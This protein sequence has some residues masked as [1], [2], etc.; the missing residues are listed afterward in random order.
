MI[1]TKTRFHSV[2][3][4]FT[5]IELLVVIS[6]IVLLIALLLPALSEAK[7]TVMVTKCMSNLKQIGIGINTYV[8]DWATYPM[9]SCINGN[10]VTS[11]YTWVD[12]RQNLV[13]IAGG[14]PG[15]WFCPLYPWQTPADYGI[16]ASENKFGPHFAHVNQVDVPGSTGYFLAFI[17]IDLAVHFGRYSNSGLYW[18]WADSGNPDGPWAAGDSSAPAVWKG[19]AGTL[20]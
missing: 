9:P 13:D 19:V 10:W 1:S 16:P 5:L 3:S 17:I 15:F 8:A 14:A 11:T 18:D 2:R 12:N 7:R 20:P 6:L 4:C